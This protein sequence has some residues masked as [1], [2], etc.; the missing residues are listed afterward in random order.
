MRYTQGLEATCADLGEAPTQGQD[1]SHIRPGY[2]RRAAAH[3]FI[4][5]RIMDYGI[6]VVRI[7]HERMLPSLHL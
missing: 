3:H 4:Y 2:R 5:H 6:A 7:L 1:C